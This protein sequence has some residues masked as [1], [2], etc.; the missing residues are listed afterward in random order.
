MSIVAAVTRAIDIFGGD[1]HWACYLSKEESD[2]Y[3]KSLVAQNRAV[4][5]DELI[6]YM[7]EKYDSRPWQLYGGI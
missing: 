2:A 5:Q 3:Y 6:M 1:D 7:A 4:M